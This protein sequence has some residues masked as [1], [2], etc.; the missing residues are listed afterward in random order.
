MGDL[1]HRPRILGQGPR[2]PRPLSPKVGTGYLN[3]LPTW[4][5]TKVEGRGGPSAQGTCS[6]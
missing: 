4:V 6:P 5:P 2:A 1:F 3:V